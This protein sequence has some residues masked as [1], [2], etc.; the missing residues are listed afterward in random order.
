MHS[1]QRPLTGTLVTWGEA[2]KGGT[3][4]PSVAVSTVAST[5]HA[6]AAISADTGE[7]LAWGLD[8]KGGNQADVP[9]GTGFT[10]LAAAMSAF[11]ALG[12][13]GACCYAWGDSAKGGKV[14]GSL[15]SLGTGYASIASTKEAFAALH[16]TDGTI[17]TWGATRTLRTRRRAAATFSSRRRRR[18]L[19]RLHGDGTVFAWGTT[20]YG[21]GTVPASAVNIT[22]L[23]ANK[24]AFAALDGHGVIHT[25]GSH[26][27]RCD[28]HA[29]RERLCRCVRNTQ[30]LRRAAFRWPQFSHGERTPLAASAHTLALR[31]DEREV[32]TFV[33]KWLGLCRGV[34]QWHAL[35][36]GQ[37]LAGG[38]AALVPSSSDRPAAC[39]LA[40]L[41]SAQ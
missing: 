41:W 25:W 37:S 26:Y 22:R 2:D 1:Q 15:A 19:P 23:Y 17:A 28:G 33:F 40:S 14:P 34:R 21:T 13:D 20:G 6:F 39:R 27:I 10:M 31:T 29:N 18:R 36:M 35:R 24:R 16:G 3:G 38:G 5:Y 12:P 8:S 9:T 32:H 11:A 7:L 30:R 4:G